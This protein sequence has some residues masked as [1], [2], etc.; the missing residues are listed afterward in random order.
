M[1]SLVYPNGLFILIFLVVHF[2]PHNR[3]Q[4]NY[5]DNR[6]SNKMCL[7]C[8]DKAQEDYRVDN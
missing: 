5:H 6:L 1:S 2:I 3:Y 8:A 4:Q 7:C